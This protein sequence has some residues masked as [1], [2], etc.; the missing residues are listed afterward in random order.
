MA[1]LIARNDPLA[2]QL[3]ELLPVAGLTALIAGFNSTGLITLNRH[4]AFSR[5][6]ALDF[7]SQIVGIGVMIGWALVHR[8]VEHR[9]DNSS[10]S[11]NG[12]L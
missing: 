6:T 12:Y 7:V 1:W 3:V 11:R 4:L 8:S 2:W 10:S 9:N 5:L